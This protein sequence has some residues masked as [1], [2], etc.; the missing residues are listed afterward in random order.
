MGEQDGDRC[1]VTVDLRRRPADQ[2]GGTGQAGVHQHPVAAR[3]AQQV[4]VHHRQPHA[5]HIG[6]Q[7]LHAAEGRDGRRG[8]TGDGRAVGVAHVP[9]PRQRT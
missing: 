6:T 2:A 5:R 3:L 9:D 8:G 7:P 4:G 1:A